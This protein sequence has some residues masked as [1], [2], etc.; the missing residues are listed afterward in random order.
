MTNSAAYVGR[1]GGLAVALGIGAA[2]A[3]SQQVAWADTPDSS[4]DPSGASASSPAPSESSSGSS[5]S[6]GSAPGHSVAGPP[7]R[8]TTANTTSDDSSATEPTADSE[9]SNIGQ[10]DTDSDPDTDK[11][12]AEKPTEIPPASTPDTDIA[13]SPRPFLSSGHRARTQTQPQADIKPTSDPETQSPSTSSTKTAY[14]EQTT[15]D[16]STTTAKAVQSTQLETSLA[17]VTVDD[18][19]PVIAESAPEARESSTT[20]PQVATTL[21]AAVGL[22]PLA[23]DS[24]LAPVTP[25]LTLFAA[26][27]WVRREILNTFFNQSP[28]IA[29]N[30]RE[31][32]LVD[33]SI[34]GTLVANDPDGTGYTLTATKPAEG[35]VVV[36]PDGTFVY[37]PGP[38]YDGGDTFSV[39][40]TEADSG[41]HIHG[42]GGLLNLVTFGL[43]G[44]SGHSTTRTISVGKDVPVQFE[45]STVVSGLESPTDF[46]I[47][48]DNRILIAEKGGAIK[49][50]N[51]TELQSEP[52]ITLPVSTVWARGVNG[53]EVDPD[54]AGNGYVYVS[55]IGDDNIQRLSRITVTDPSAEVLTADPDS[56]VVLVEGTEPAG[57]DHHGG[58]LRFG[59]DGK[60]YWSTGDNVCCSVLDGS[61][62]QD[63]TNMYGK[64]LRLNPDGTAPTDN[65]FY[66]GPDPTGD[67]PTTTT[68]SMPPA[69]ATR[70][71]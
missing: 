13:D 23:T 1:V 31:N 45:R 60:L 58:G 43:L 24:P 62:S 70:S 25:P 55:Y 29:Y 40:V 65:P 4:S 7:A 32:S 21:L 5:G 68:P 57:D 42:L 30:P 48:P 22:S 47:L 49:V 41:F 14:I 18:S 44:E 26:L 61:N 59:P 27:E 12:A 6:S 63:L 71:G 69:S 17:A 37:T 66:D 39:T 9:G 3:C 50:Y 15:V 38:D 28:T 67:P 16:I 56:L 19:Q 35:E 34:V 2:V 64:V 53:I 51:G 36:N 20:E 10:V 8:S 33:G 11:S 52:L 46:R 54:F